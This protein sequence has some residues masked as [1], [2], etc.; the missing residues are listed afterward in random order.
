MYSPLWL[1][2]CP[3]RGMSA[4]RWEIPATKKAATTS[5]AAWLLSGL[6]AWRLGGLAAWRLGG[7]AAW[8]LGGLAAWLLG[9]LAALL[10]GRPA[11]WQSDCLAASL[12]PPYGEG[13]TRSWV[14]KRTES[15]HLPEGFEQ[16]MSLWQSCSYVLLPL[17]GLLAQPSALPAWLPVDRSAAPHQPLKHGRLPTMRSRKRMHSSGNQTKP[18]RREGE[19]DSGAKGSSKLAWL[20]RLGRHVGVVEG[21]IYNTS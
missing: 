21:A 8:R 11:S 4:A 19:G 17:P 6:A 13:R 2:S 3:L 5:V 1:R 14:A 15:S 10:P 20:A 12:R 18:N 16:L 7:L 9:C